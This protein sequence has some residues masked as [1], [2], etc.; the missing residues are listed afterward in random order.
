MHYV[1][2]YSISFAILVRATE[3]EGTILYRLLMV[4]FY[5]LLS[6][7]VFA[8][9]DFY[10]LKWLETNSTL[11][12]EL[13][14]PDQLT[15]LY[16]ENQ[17]QVIWYDKESIDTFETYLALL[18]F[19]ELSPYFSIRYK[20]LIELKQHAK[21]YE[22]DLLATDTLLTYQ[23]YVTSSKDHGLLWFYGNQITDVDV[24]SEKLDMALIRLQIQKDDLAKY[25][26]S[27]APTRT[28]YLIVHRTLNQLLNASQDRLEK[29]AQVGQKR[30]GDSLLNKKVLIAR[31][32]AVGLDTSKVE[33]KS[34]NLDPEL[35]IVLE[36]FQRMHGLKPDGII[37]KKTLYWINYP[38]R[39]RIRS[40]ALNLERSRL[41]PSGR[42]NVILV[43]LPS[44]QISYWSKGKEVFSSKVIVGKKKRKTPLINIKMD[45]LIFNPSWRVPRKIVKEDIIPAVKKDATYLDKNN[46]KIIET[47]QSEK[48]IPS[49]T[50]DWNKVT[51][52]NFSYQLIQAPGMRNAL[53]QYKFNTPNPRAIYLHDT[54][55]KYLFDEASRAYSS[56]CIRIQYADELVQTVLETQGIDAPDSIE[57][58]D[59]SDHRVSLKQKIPV[60]ILYQTAWLEEGVVQYRNDIYDYDN[61]KQDLV[62]TIN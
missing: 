20:R 2:Q 36:Q 18:H 46:F 16:R 31:F 1:G 21:I 45:S 52:E 43:N 24:L 15:T 44:F 25:L 51:P 34:K 59:Q 48:E 47:W 6:L 56:G 33:I 27:I 58:K 9:E 57:I 35:V 10:R 30:L 38:I 32:S 19:S 62:L 22:Y 39:E 41:Q 42:D 29:Y 55:A 49:D 53:G 5:A 60:H 37:G 28:H 12:N 50:L 13:A 11:V 3:I 54:P 14:H 26:W 40:L 4:L 7:P 23:Q 17:Y 61:R 8:L